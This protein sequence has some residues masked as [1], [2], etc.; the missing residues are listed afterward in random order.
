MQFSVALTTFNRCGHVVA[1][2]KSCLSQGDF[3]AEVVVVDDASADDTAERI[4]DLHESK[5]RYIRR[6][7]NGGIGAARADAFTNCSS[8]WIV[9][10]D[11]DH[12]MLPGALAFLSRIVMGLPDAVGIVGGR[13]QWDVGGVSPKVIPSEVIDY[14]GRI[15]WSSLPDSIGCDYVFCVR[16]SVIQRVAW[17]KKRSGLVDTLFQLDCAKRTNA[18]FVPKTLCIQ[19]TDATHSHTRGTAE[20]R[21]RRRCLDAE[22]GVDVVREILSRH[23]SALRSNGPVKY[24]SILTMGAFYAILAGEKSLALRWLISG[25]RS[26]GVSL[27]RAGLIGSLVVGQRLLELVYK[28]RARWRS[29]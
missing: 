13:H 23:E 21:W 2:I 27:E 5:V 29:S 4:M 12:E 8:E 1:A 22:D 20:A 14:A 3:L 19:K 7:A 17:S 9:A 25:I 11:S 15:K 6:T 18:K 26:G 24:S 10:L 16:R 28:T